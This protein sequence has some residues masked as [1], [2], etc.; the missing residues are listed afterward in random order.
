M[1]GT[2]LN[3]PL[4]SNW[5]LSDRENTSRSSQQR[6]S[7]KKLL[8]ILQYLEENSLFFT[9]MLACGLFSCKYCEIF[10]NI[11]FEE[12]LWTTASTSPR[13]RQVC[14]W[15]KWICCCLVSLSRRAYQCSPVLCKNIKCTRKSRKEACL[16]KE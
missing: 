15:K 11:Y 5:P 4:V 13:K 16:Y 10:K 8:K 1:H 2:A 3:M 9:K 7:I 6:L 12:H 14:S